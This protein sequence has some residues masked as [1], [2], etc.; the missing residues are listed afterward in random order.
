MFHEFV[1]QMHRFSHASQKKDAAD[2]M[3]KPERELGK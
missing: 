3:K 1:R 2:A